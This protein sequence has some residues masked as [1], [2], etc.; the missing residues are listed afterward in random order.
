MEMLQFLKK[1]NKRLALLTSS[2][3]STID[4][5]L[6]FH[7]LKDFFEVVVTGDTVTHH[8]PHPECIEVALEALGISGDKAVMVGDS[9]NDLGAARNAG[10]D[11]LLYYPQTHQLFYDLEKLKVDK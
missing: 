2:M 4:A 5:V 11:S 8:K 1:Q 9:A 3:G 6:E 7:Q 10:I